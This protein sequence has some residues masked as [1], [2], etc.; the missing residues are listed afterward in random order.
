MIVRVLTVLN[1]N[2]SAGV[3]VIVRVVTVLSVNLSASVSV[4][5]SLSAGVSI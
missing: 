4:Y 2:S 3:S 1:V 5:V